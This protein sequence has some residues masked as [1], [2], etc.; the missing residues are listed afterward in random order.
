MDLCYRKLS[1]VVDRRLHARTRTTQLSRVVLNVILPKRWKRVHNE[2][3]S[4][5]EG[6]SRRD[7]DDESSDEETSAEQQIAA[8]REMERRRTSSSLS[9]STAKFSKGLSFQRLITRVQSVAV[10]CGL[11]ALW[12]ASNIMYNLFNKQV[13]QAFPLATTCTLIHLIVASFLMSILWILRLKKVSTSKSLYQIKALTLVHHLIKPPSMA[14]PNRLLESVYPLA[15]LHLMGFLT[16]NMSLGAVN[17]SLTHTIKSLEPFFTVFLSYLFYGVAPSLTIMLTLVPIVAGVIVASATDLS[18]NWYGFLTAMGSNLAFQSRNVISKQLMVESSWESLEGGGP[19]PMDEVNLF[20]LISIVALPMMV[21][22]VIAVDGPTLLGKFCSAGGC[23]IIVEPAQGPNGLAYLMSEVSSRVSAVMPG[24]VFVKTVLAGICRTLDVVCSFALL[25]R[26]SPVT[27]SVGNCVKRVVVI[28][29]SILFFNTA[30]SYLN[31]IGT[32]LALSGVFA[33][34]MAEKAAKKKGQ[35]PPGVA[36]ATV[37]IPM[38]TFLAG[39]VPDFIKDR[40]ASRQGSV[41]KEKEKKKGPSGQDPEYF[42]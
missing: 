17:V 34:S 39:L 22:I 25:S 29:A 40:I 3:A 33:Y 13:L 23:P 42:L 27:H 21:P 26:L 36:G 4:S 30:A 37:E 6:A 31:I 7:D 20:A 8:A 15:I 38:Q 12:Y 24:D 18:F 1:S 19:A 28:A 35:I 10:I 11:L 16:T 9:S 5:S 41:E 2:F 32:A 14:N